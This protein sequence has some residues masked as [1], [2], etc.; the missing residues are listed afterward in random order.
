M[1][2]RAKRPR[3]G[4]GGS[5]R[6]QV[7][8]LLGDTCYRPGEMTV[9]SQPSSVACAVAGVLTVAIVFAGC[10]RESNPEA[11]ANNPQGFCGL[12]RWCEQRPE[13]S[14]CL[15]VP[16]NPA[17]CGKERWPGECVVARDG[18]SDSG[19]RAD[20]SERDATV[21]PDD[22]GRQMPDDTG[23]QIDLIADRPAA[24]KPPDSASCMNACTFG[25]RQCASSIEVQECVAESN[26]CTRWRTN[27]PCEAPK[28]CTGSAAASCSCP[29]VGC[30]LGAEECGP[31]GGARQCVLTNGCPMWTAETAC[32][33]PRT[34]VLM[35]GRASCTCSKT[36]NIGAKECGPGGGPRECVSNMGCPMWG[37]EATCAAVGSTCLRGMCLCR[38]QS[39]GNRLFNAG[40]DL[41]L[42]GW[43][44]SGGTWSNQD[45]DT[46]VGSGS[47]LFNAMDGGYVVS[48]CVSVSAGDVY[49]FGARMKVPSTALYGGVCELFL[50]TGTDCTIR[51]PGDG[52][53]TVTIFSGNSVSWQTVEKGGTAV[54][55]EIQS[56]AVNC[57][58][59][60]GGSGQFFFDQVYL[61]K[62]PG[63]F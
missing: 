17:D 30:T 27:S 37:S 21:M 12:G 29:T 14:Q 9:E 45:A 51:N 7:E 24:D 20:A 31:G 61:T 50:R 5:H 63:T 15:P 59:G 62:T 26:G 56:A 2:T 53:T 32:G 10:A 39:A 4:R 42:D 28:T 47:V 44:G 34:C 19:G 58:V 46:C 25:A 54:P 23:G 41:G 57:S 43:K 52:S 16:L 40:F 48:D 8:N 18:S 38:R 35:D 13:S 36:C 60:S 55:A 1:T 49:S 6:E 33:A 11:C 3:H 22:T